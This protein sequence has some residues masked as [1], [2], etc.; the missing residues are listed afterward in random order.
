MG[1]LRSERSE[2]IVLATAENGR[3]LQ[4]A[5][6]CSQD[7][8]SSTQREKKKKEKLMVTDEISRPVQTRLPLR[9]R[10]ACGDDVVSE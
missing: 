8:K 7:P 4:R 10:G 9:V 1:S 6:R 5:Q 2:C 3:A